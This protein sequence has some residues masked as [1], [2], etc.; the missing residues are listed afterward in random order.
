MDEAQPYRENSHQTAANA[1]PNDMPADASDRPEETYTE[2]ERNAMR[3]YLQR[4]EVRLSTL[5]RV[6]TA[7]V[8]GAG[9]LLLIPVFL[10][11]VVEGIVYA[12][13]RVVEIHYEPLG[14]T[15]SIL[16]TLALY[17]TLFYPFILSLCIPMYGMYLLLK[18]IVQFYFTIYSPDFA[19]DLLHPTFALNAVAFS[20]DESPRVKRAIMR[21]Q[22]ASHQ[23]D[24]MLPFSQGRREQYFDRLEHETNGAIIPASRTMENLHA[25]DALPPGYDPNEVRRFNI[26]LG[27]ARAYDRNLVEEVAIAEMALVRHTMYIRR[28]VLRYVKTLLML[29]WTIV[30]SFVLLPFLG[31][32]RFSTL[33]VLAMG[34]LVWSLGVMPIIQWPIAWL[35][36]HRR[37]DSVAP[38][39]DTQIVYMERRIRPFCNLAVVSS[40]AGLI[41]VILEIATR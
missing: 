39:V 17:A 19:H 21:Y 26:A 32:T 27:I 15:P 31:D 23:M 41:L 10:R 25:L 6:V 29:I 30:I 18:D 4:S 9:L 34:Y 13:L 36:R 3:G 5:H 2:Q 37:G 7:F 22:Y 1:S 38:H 35:Y 12:W 11:D 28:L 8:G 16:L 33:L 40:F 24:Y 14:N 20:T